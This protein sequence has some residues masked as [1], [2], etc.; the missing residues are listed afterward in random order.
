MLFFEQPRY[1]IFFSYLIS[2]GSR[3]FMFSL[4]VDWY[5]WGEEAFEKARKRNVPIFLSSAFA[6]PKSHEYIFISYFFLL[7]LVCTYL[8]LSYFSLI[9]FYLRIL[10]AFDMGFALQVGYSTCHW[11]VFFSILSLALAFAISLFLLCSCCK[12]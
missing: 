9:V 3:L 4:K 10:L 6:K 7:N 1:L 5:P 8:A 2:L 12:S 11:S